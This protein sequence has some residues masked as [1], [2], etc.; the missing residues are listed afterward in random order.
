MLC[1]QEWGSG[2]PVIALHP[3]AL[4]STVF[5]GVAEGL[6][7]HDLRTLA[8]DLPGFG[9]SP[10]PDGPLTPAVL[11]EPVIELARSLDAPPILLG[12]SMGGRVALEA[13]L[14]EP[15]VFRGV[16]LVAPYLPWRE[17]RWALS[18]SRLIQ[19]ALAERVP[20]EHAW[21]LLKGITDTLEGFP[22]I[23]E[24]WFARACVRVS[25]YLSCPATRR[26]FLSA[27]RELALD[28]AFG[29]EGLWTRLAELQA[30]A[31][32]VWAE[33]D[34]LIPGDH[35]G[36]VE[37]LLP[38]VRQVRVPCS[39]HFMNGPHFRCFEAAMANAVLRVRADATCLED[40]AEPRSQAGPRFERAACLVSGPMGQS[41][42]E[43]WQ[44]WPA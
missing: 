4:E 20:L 31:S 1:F 12:M 11:A 40:A 13:R 8:V 32:F 7:N 3:L 34:R 16:V 30:P 25:Y 29:P 9:R 42:A 41:P 36:H 18:L 38:W 35:A 14:R 2:E 10:G 15:D 6:A 27:T 28:R 26:H 23:R 24:D 44:E 37:A 43:S 19:P 17:S 39:G 21:P 5:I 33:R 22:S